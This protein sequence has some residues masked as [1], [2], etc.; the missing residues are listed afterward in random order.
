MLSFQGS[1]FDKRVQG[2][3]GVFKIMSVRVGW[4]TAILKPK[5]RF[6]FNSGLIRV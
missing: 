6:G 2:V 1:L 5:P 3:F 4:Q